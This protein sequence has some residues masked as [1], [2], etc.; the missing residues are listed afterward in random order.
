MELSFTNNK[1]NIKNA[2]A[3]ELANFA[4][5]LNKN[6][7]IA[8]VSNT[9]NTKVKSR[10]KSKND[11]KITTSN[12]TH[13]NINRKVELLKLLEIDYSR[14]NMIKLSTEYNIPFNTIST[15]LYRHIKNKTPLKDENGNVVFQSTVEYKIVKKNKKTKKKTTTK[16]TCSKY[17]EELRNVVVEEIKK[18]HSLNNMKLISEKYNVNINTLYS[19]LRTYITNA[20]TKSNEMTYDKWRLEVIYP[21]VDKL[22]LS[23][24]TDRRVILS[25]MYKKMNNIYG[26]VWPQLY[27]DYFNKYGSKSS[28][29]LRSIYYLEKEVPYG[30]YGNE[31]YEDLLENLL[32]E[33]ISNMN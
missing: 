23:K 11:T 8:E 27:K 12:T 10:T 9:Q 24:G 7:H 32:K 25:S 5:L 4:K 16:R 3:E 1:I 30:T 29:T 28:S 18:D 31:H 19:W 20:D 17:S 22:A 33:D 14:D 6:E 15:W 26:I 2:T 21:L 13:N